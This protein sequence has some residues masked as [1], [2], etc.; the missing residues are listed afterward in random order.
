VNPIV[1]AFSYNFVFELADSLGIPFF[2]DCELHI[3]TVP[4]VT[5]LSRKRVAVVEWFQYQHRKLDL[6]WADLVVCFTSEIVTDPWDTYLEKTQH[7]FN[8]K[9]IIIVT[10]GI[11]R[12]VISSYSSD[13]LHYPVPSFLLSVVQANNS[14][15]YTDYMSSRPYLFDA[16]LGVKKS[17]RVDIFNRLV[18]DGLLEK[19]LVSLSTGRFQ[20]QPTD[21][22]DYSSPALDYLDDPDVLDFK[23]EN[24]GDIDLMYSGR[25]VHNRQYKINSGFRPNMSHIV[26]HRVYQNSWYS[27]VSE[28]SPGEID[29]I[30]EKTAKCLFGRRIFVMF[31]PAQ[32]L[33]FLHRLGFKTFNDILDESY[34]NE[35]DNIKRFDMAWQ[36]I[37]YLSTADPRQ[38]YSKIN[39]VLEHN[40]QLINDSKQLL[41]P[42]VNFVQEQIG[43]L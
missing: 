39:H 21:V 12:E 43:K 4:D 17:F 38:L 3:D 7:H 42:V 26:P 9:K 25:P 35:H 28:T 2:Q 20:D 11:K 15:D 34:D 14:V 10:G 27:I 40:Y 30:T 13:Q 16:L 24:A 32:H 33:A 31:G 23:K 18:N 41:Q 29:F 5:D 1:R 8:C 6:S 22:V 19:S 36:Q 37:K